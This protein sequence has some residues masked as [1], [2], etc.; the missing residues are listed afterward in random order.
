MTFGLQYLDKVTIS[1]AAVYGMRA[2]LNL[3]GQDYSWAV[4]LFYFGYLVGQPPASYLMQK[5]PIGKFAAVNLFI[6]GGLVMCCA[7]AKNMAGLSVLRFLMGLF[8]AGIG[9]CF[10]R[11]LSAM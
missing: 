9:M 3:K 4:T 7:G 11:Q 6:W 8:E 10:T 5:F 2:E 1:Y